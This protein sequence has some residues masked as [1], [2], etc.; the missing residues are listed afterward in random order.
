MN[1][2]FA[3]T[4]Y[5]PA[6]GVGRF[7][8]TLLRVSG[9][10]ASACLARLVGPLPAP[11]RA[12]LRGIMAP[13]G[14]LLDRAMVLWL[15]GPQ[16]YTGE[17]SFELHLHGGLAVL[18]G[19]EAALLSLGLRPAEPG[20]FTRR[21]FIHGRMDLLEAEAVAD[22]IAAETSAQRDQALRQLSGELGG[23]YRDWQGRLVRILAQQ[24]ALIDF[25]DE[26][27]PAEVEA[28]LL[29]EIV[30]LMAAM[31]QHLKDGDRGERLRR[32]LVLALAGLPNVGKSSLVNTLCRRDVAIVSPV[33]GTTRDVIEVRLDLSGIPVTLQDLA[34][35]RETSDPVEVEGVRRAQ[36]R[37]ASADIVLQVVAPPYDVLPTLD[38]W[39]GARV[40]KVA[41]KS[42]LGIPSPEGMVRVSSLTG[43]G[44]DHL[45]AMLGE[46]AQ[47][48]AGIGE[49]PSLTRARH[50]AAVNAAAGHLHA[51]LDV[52]GVEL[53]GEELRLALRSLGRILGSVGVEEL[54]DSVFSQFCIG[55]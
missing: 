28:G 53:R 32:G 8:I 35:L 13:D 14:S 18:T 39:V 51:A 16:T 5:A 21:A 40:I 33:P 42:D 54:L 7:A 41:S 11:R 47:S 45:V 26:D 23:V 1:G 3:D 12:V 46:V 55:K 29:A 22:L 30:S 25:P 52:S 44:C 34:G 37:V 15:P 27:L 19:V 50:R 10:E 17:D 4:I 24:E 9:A 31:H 36:D 2:L 48:L 6:S 49:T 43:E 20:E 38:V